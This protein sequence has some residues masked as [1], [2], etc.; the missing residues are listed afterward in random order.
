MHLHPQT[1]RLWLACS[2]LA[3]VALVTSA[4]LPLWTM[5]LHAPQY[6]RGLTLTAYG[7]RLEGDI[8]EVNTVNHYVGVEPVH[9]DSIP[10]L[11]LFPYLLGGLVVLVVLA[12]FYARAWWMRAIVSL[13]LWGFV[14]GFLIDLQWWLYHS[15]HERN[16]DA[17]Y[18]IDDFTPRVLGG[19]KVVNFESETM[20][21]LGYWMI[22]AAAVLVTFGPPVVRFLV[23]SW[24]NTG[25]TEDRAVASPGQS[26]ARQ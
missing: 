10:E 20:V 18:R 2:L 4:W 7:T 5:E 26:T 8:Q 22:V 16:S 11:G 13:S 21:A 25:T 3:A 17:P 23:A 14:V 15:G 19:T 24:R 9:T 12:G 1:D 6:P